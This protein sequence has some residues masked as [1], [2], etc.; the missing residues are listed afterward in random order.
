M[1]ALNG[2]SA[3]QGSISVLIPVRNEELNIAPLLNSIFEQ[4][5][6]P[7]E[8]IVIDD[9]SDDQT[10][11]IAES[12]GVT[13][14]SAPALPEDW[15]GK[16]W[17]LWNGYLHSRGE[18]LVFLDADVRLHRNALQTLV[19][20]RQRQGGVISVLP[21]HQAHHF[22]EKFA[23]LLNMLMVFAF[24]SPFERSNRR[25]GLFGA[26]IVTTRKDYD[27]IDGHRSIRSKLLDDMSLGE[28]FQQAGI[29]VT[30]YIGG[31]VIQF[32]MYPDGMKSE[33][34][35]FS[36]E[37]ALGTA[38]FRILTII[39]MVLWIV[40]LIAADSFLF[41]IG[42]PYFVPLLIAY[43]LYVLQFFYFNRY[44]GSFGVVH[45]ILH[46]LSTLFFFVILVLS[47]YQSFIRRRVMWKGRYIDIGRGG[48]Q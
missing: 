6:R 45:P 34:E 3:K 33:V 48:T 31:E 20:E 7:D 16:N 24:A 28:R 15:T 22:Y 19:S 44:I 30:N 14:L 46:F 4:A 25:K 18:I 17:A 42:T 38:S 11:A 5:I 8:V 47:V 10:K 40:C 1:K 32:R 43:S 27:T 26:C 39:P 13:V 23:M 12:Y 9:H 36:K 35:G 29:R 41:F 37:V 21:Y 2:S